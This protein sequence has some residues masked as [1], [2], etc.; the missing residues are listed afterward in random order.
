MNVIYTKK[1]KC[2]E[3][4]GCIRSCLVKAVK[5]IG[6]QATIM[7]DRCI[8][9]GICVNACNQDAIYYKN[10]VNR[11]KDVLGRMG[12]AIAILDSTFPAAF[13]GMNCNK[14]VAALKELGFDE[15]WESA[16]GGEVINEKYQ[17]ILRD[18]SSSDMY[19]TSHCSA[20][21][22]I[23]ERHYPVLLPNLI[24]LISPMFVTS[25]IIKKKYPNADIIF[26]GPCVSK[27]VEV[28]DPNIEDGIEVVITYE[29]LKELLKEK[30]IDVNKLPEG[31][32]DGYPASFSRLFL[33]IGGMVAHTYETSDVIRL[34]ND[35]LTLDGPRALETI[36]ELASGKKVKSK[37]LDI[38]FCRGCID[39]PA[40]GVDKSFFKKRENIVD[41]VLDKETKITDDY[42]RFL[43]G[44]NVRREFSNRQVA[45]KK[46]SKDE[47]DKVLRKIGGRDKKENA[48]NCGACGYSSC[49]EKAIAVTQGIADEQLC[50]PSL[51]AR[52]ASEKNRLIEVIINSMNDVVFT[53]DK[54]LEIGIFNDMAEKFSDYSKDEVR[55][56]LCQDIFCKK[57]YDKECDFHKVLTTGK[58]VVDH[59]R[60]I[61]TK[62]GKRIQVSASVAPL[63][64]AEGNITGGVEV[65][66][67]ITL[68]KEIDKMKSGFVSNVSH[69]LRTPLT[70]IK[71]S[72]ELLLGEAEGHVEEGQRIFLNI[73]KNNTERLIRLVSD[74]LDLAKIESGKVEMHKR[75][76]DINNLVEEVIVS[77]QPLSEEKSIKIENVVTG[78]TKVMIDEDRI[79]QVLVNLLSNSIKFS[80]PEGLIEITGEEK[81][82]E[83]KIN[84]S[85]NGIGIDSTNFTKIFTKFQNIDVPTSV[86]SRVKGTNLGL[87]ICKNIIEAHGGTIWVE[88]ELQKG[89]T[90]SFTIPKM[91]KKEMTDVI[92]VMSKGEKVIKKVL[93]VDDDQDVVKVIKAYLMREGMEVSVAYDGNEAIRKAMED[94]PDIITLDILMPGKNGF[95]VIEELRMY[96]E[97]KSIPIVI[98]SVIQVDNQEKLF[99]LG[100][101][102]YLNKPIE[103]NKLISC[104]KTIEKWIKSPGEKKT[105]LI[106]DDEKD[107]VTV[108]RALLQEHNYLTMEAYNGKEA[109]EMTERRKPDLIIMD[110][111]MPEMNGFEAIRKIKLNKDI[112]HIPII[113]L[114][115]R[116][117]EEDKIKALMLG[118]SEY[119]NKPFT[120]ETL[121]NRIK[122]K[123]G[124]EGV[125]Y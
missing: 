6:K 121:I 113:V 52:I 33:A 15:V 123:L 68:L 76:T 56:K 7:G 111:V 120:K 5:V 22:N 10:E 27:K 97:T 108:I 46:V 51:I 13:N 34:K 37:I 107:V 12:K 102:D 43:E 58:P 2:K 64:D 35:V 124:E 17:E 105:I 11:V 79:K 69:E 88:S 84:V 72:V 57:A 67:D 65:L 75:L 110:I 101:A 90:F 61:T 89:S 3:C 23:I 8:S 45:F 83:I 122:D 109:V 48:L 44:I 31:E 99:R 85:D 78:L 28:R 119:L 114:T 106:V 66:R 1:G 86:S 26:I 82:K 115:V 30:K 21:I 117:L 20:I 87:S 112:A 4:Y 18:S 95:E 125:A 104:I 59:E 70:S 91:T 16:L 41:Y 38:Y 98:I 81:A 40:M 63:F 116:N 118:A 50:L 29:E 103:P 25:K 54:N 80:P 71:G 94:V 9:C 55:G 24:P 96:E 32:L 19:I 73:I 36:R 47:V 60:E 14:I 77:V 62:G 74:L 39:G 49:K 53:M 92:K 42:R 93:V 100:I